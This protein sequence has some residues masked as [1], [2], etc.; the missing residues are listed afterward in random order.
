MFEATIHIILFAF[1]FVL[2][3]VVVNVD[4]DSLSKGALNEMVVAGVL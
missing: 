3:V 2:Q 1:S 4:L